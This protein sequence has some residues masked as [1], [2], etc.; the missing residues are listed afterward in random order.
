M[1]WLVFI[2]VLAK[3]TIVLSCLSLYLL[4]FK[5]RMNKTQIVLL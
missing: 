3:V 1:C 2:V 5:Q 4:G